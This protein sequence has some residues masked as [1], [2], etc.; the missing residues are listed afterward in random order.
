M[1]KAGNEILKRKHRIRS[2][3]IRLYW[4]ERSIALAMINEGYLILEI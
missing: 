4:I 2:I 1:S 3:A